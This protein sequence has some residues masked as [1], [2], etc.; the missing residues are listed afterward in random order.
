MT[1]TT[2]TLNGLN[3]TQSLG[4]TGSIPENFTMR[5]GYTSEF[6]KAFAVDT[7]ALT[8]EQLAAKETSISLL[9]FNTTETEITLLDLPVEFMTKFNNGEYTF[10]GNVMYI[11]FVSSGATV[12]GENKVYFAF[13]LAKTIQNV[14]ISGPVVF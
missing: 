3:I 9:A 10:D 12:S 4:T 1:D 2:L 7:T 11:E 8:A 5:V 6:V 13:D 14:E